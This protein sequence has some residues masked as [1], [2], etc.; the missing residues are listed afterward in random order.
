MTAIWRG[1]SPLPDP[2]VTKP[3]AAAATLTFAAGLLDQ[4]A[5]YIAPAVFGAGTLDSG[6]AYYSE[7]NGSSWT[8][9]GNT[10]I[11]IAL[12]GTT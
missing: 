2:V 10:D 1:A 9:A 4:Y 3:A 6:A 8:Q 11:G 12:I 5:A 7:N